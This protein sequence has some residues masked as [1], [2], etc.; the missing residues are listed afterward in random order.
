MRDIGQGT[1]MDPSTLHPTKERMKHRTI[2]RG[3]IWYSWRVFE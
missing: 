2:M 3:H 1:E